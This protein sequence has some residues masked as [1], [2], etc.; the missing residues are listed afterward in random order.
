MPQKLLWCISCTPYTGTYCFT[1][2][3]FMEGPSTIWKDHRISQVDGP[4]D[5]LLIDP[6]FYPCDL[7]LI[8]CSLYYTICDCFDTWWHNCYIRGYYVLLGLCRYRWITGHCPVRA[9][10][11]LGQWILYLWQLYYMLIRVWLLSLVIGE[12]W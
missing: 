3:A 12:S 7:Y 6:Y 9:L 1:L 11:V 8:T 10:W 2:L 4:M 5:H